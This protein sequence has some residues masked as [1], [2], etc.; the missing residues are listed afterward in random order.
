MG[1]SR[2]TVCFRKVSLDSG[3]KGYVEKRKILGQEPP[4][5]LLVQMKRNDV[6]NGRKK[7]EMGWVYIV[8]WREN[9]E[10]S[11]TLCVQAAE[12]QSRG[13]GRPGDLS[14]VG[15]TVAISGTLDTSVRRRQARWMDGQGNFEEEDV[16]GL[17]RINQLVIDV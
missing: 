6:L 5:P 1:F 13:L 14:L 11:E 17:Y 8:L 9:R 12:G 7:A 15:G 3:M 2:T 4:G 10:D 16:Q